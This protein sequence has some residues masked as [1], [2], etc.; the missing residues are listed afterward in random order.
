[1]PVVHAAVDDSAACSG[2]AASSSARDRHACVDDEFETITGG[3]L[4]PERFFP[5]RVAK[6]APSAPELVALICGLRTLGAR[7]ERRA[8]A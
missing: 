4:A 7:S 5:G 6:I 1:M 2:R 8:V 3:R